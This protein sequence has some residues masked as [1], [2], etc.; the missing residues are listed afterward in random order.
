MLHAGGGLTLAL[1][2]IK[3]LFGRARQAVFVPYALHDQE[4][5]T[6]R[7]RSRYFDDIGVDLVGLHTITNPADAI[8]GAGAIVVGGG[9]TFRLLKVLQ[10]LEL[11][12]PIRE[13]VARGVPYFGASAGANVAGLSI[14]T[15]N[16]MPIVQPASFAA[17]GLVPFQVNPH[18]VDSPPG[19]PGETRE[20]RLAEFLEENDVAVVGLREDS[21]LVVEEGGMQLRGPAGAVLLRRG[22]RARRLRPGQDLS[23]LLRYP[24]RFDAPL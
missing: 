9:N 2:Q 11:L 6:T 7:M 14:R 21:W 8:A 24:A 19:T 15:T 18:Y 5:V 10:E 4:A 12:D 3:Q 23:A 16:D 20:V 22:H 1:P 13:A 17:L